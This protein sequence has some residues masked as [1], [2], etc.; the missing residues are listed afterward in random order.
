ML[1]ELN[2]TSRAG[3]GGDGDASAPAVTTYEAEAPNHRLFARERWGFD[4]TRLGRRARDLERQ[5][6]A[7]PGGGRT[8]EEKKEGHDYEGGVGGGARNLEG[9][10]AGEAHPLTDLLGSSLKQILTSHHEYCV[11]TALHPGGETR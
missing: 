7:S 10:G 8:E 11:R 5:A 4:S 1:L 6:N 3:V 2:V 9:A